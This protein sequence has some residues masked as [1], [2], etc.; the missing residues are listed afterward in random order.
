MQTLFFRSA[1]ALFL[2]FNVF[3][4][5]AKYN[6]QII[7]NNPSLQSLINPISDSADK[8]TWIGADVAT[9]IQL[10]EKKYVWIFG[11]TLLGSVSSQSRTMNNMLHNTV[12]I[13]TCEK[14][15]VQCQPIQKYYRTH[16]DKVDSIFTLNN[17]NQYFWPTT[18][19]QLTTKLFIAGPIIRSHSKSNKWIDSAGTVFILVDNPLEA[20]SNWKYHIYTILNTA[21]KLNWSTAA[22][23]QGAW[24]Y[25]FGSLKIGE[26]NEKT[27]AVLSR[28]SLQDAEAAH[29]DK[30]EY[31]L[32]KI[33]GWQTRLSSPTA[34][35]ILSGLTGCSEMSLGHNDRFGWYT[36]LL[37]APFLSYDAHFYTANELT[38]PWTD[39]GII[40][41]V[42][43]PW[44]P[45][46]TPDGH[47]GFLTY[48]AKVHPELA[49][50]ENDIVF[51]YNI[52]QIDTNHLFS[53][54]KEPRYWG[55]YIPQ[56]VEIKLE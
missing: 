29:W 22:V 48:A 27:N 45:A 10:D 51:T 41:T 39:Q 13:T 32:G 47:N 54:L 11:D 6:Y 1:L 5:H 12:G 33:K 14:Y 19:S 7:E 52:N 34:L 21:D 20:P 3:A 31:W 2:T 50:T 42:P 17:A 53:D 24:L 49:K 43:G 40:Y 30:M 55:L 25:I 8:N 46:E 37:P 28:I 4:V 15:T 36:V 38:G 35:G 16:H 44:N 56:F 18:G 9:S 26:H 23:K